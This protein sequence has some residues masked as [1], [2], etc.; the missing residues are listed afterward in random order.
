MNTVWSKLTRSLRAF[1]AARAGNV[2]ITFALASLP[3]VGTIGFAVDYSRA[4]SVKV[5]IQSAL[6]STA[7]MLSK[8]AA[9]ITNTDLQTR[10]L[11]YFNSLFNNPDVTGIAVNAVYSTT[12]GSHLVVSATGSV[13]TNFL[14]LIGYNAITVGGTAT[15]A[16]GSTRLRV[17]LVLD[18]TGSMADDGKMTALKS[19]T[20]N[21]LTQL[22]SA[23]STNGDVY[24]SIVPFSRD[25]RV[26]ASSNYNASWIDWTDWAAPPA[27]SMPSMSVG[28]GSNCPYS[29]WTN[30]FTC[31]PTP[32]ST[33]TTS[34]IPSSGTYSGY[35]CPSVNSST[36]SY[37]NG[38]YNSTQY[39]ANGSSASCSGHSNCTCTNT[40]SAKHCATNSGYY[41]HAW[42]VNDKSTW[43][44]CITDRGDPLSTGATAPSSADY[45]R[46][47]SAP[48]S[49][50]TAS[51]Y[52]A[53][54]YSMCT[55]A[56]MGLNYNWAAM[57]SM[58]D[59]L[60]PSG[61]TN[62]P[63]GL[64]WGW[65]SLV[66]GGPLT[67]PAKDPDYSYTDVIILMSDG[68]NTQD[69]WYSSQSSI[70]KRMYDS[71]KSGIGTCA[72]IKNSGVTIYTIQV[73]TGGDPTST[74]LQNCAGSP[75]KLVD[76][77]KFYMVTSANG[78]GAVFTEI[79]TNLT[80]L[81]VAN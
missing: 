80:K 73:N 31:S 3:V 7:L 47:V 53:E 15:A 33:S 46:L 75:E 50:T 1:R 77:S 78:L 76:T 66:G 49:G 58:V 27:N 42:V 20:K 8:D 11:A 65:Q 35:I 51:Y 6:D 30:G 5:A 17:A 63:V 26:D 55:T 68:L 34:R 23:A 61:N 71:T 12:G 4:N 74:L 60:T 29:S 79:G 18:T 40:G 70:D 67:A 45:D 21:L 48:V 22:S 81:R 52:P 9:T 2:A 38:C 62:Q 36:G 72:N 41:E 37:Y 54:Q 43:N 14:G 64:V 19:S 13:A 32:T 69:R 44:G 25:V 28:P 16:W 56:M 57:S 10:A 39:S 24:V 59:S